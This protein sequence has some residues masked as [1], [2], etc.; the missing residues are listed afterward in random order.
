MPDSLTKFKEAPTKKVDDST[1]SDGG[2]SDDDEEEVEIVTVLSNLEIPQYADAINGD[3]VLLNVDNIGTLKAGDTIFSSATMF[4]STDKGAGRVIQVVADDQGTSGKVLAR[5]ILATIGETRVFNE[6]DFIDNCAL[7]YANCAVGASTATK[8]G[9]ASFYFDPSGAPAFSRT[10]TVNSTNPVPLRFRV[11]PDLPLGVSLNEET[12]L[13]QAPVVPFT[14]ANTFDL[15][16]YTFFAEVESGS[17]GTALSEE[18]VTST[19]DSISSKVGTQPTAISNY[20]FS[21][22]LLDTDRILITLANTTGIYDGDVLYSCL[23]STFTSCNTN[24][25]YTGIGTVYHVDTDNNQVYLTVADVN[26]PANKS[27]FLDGYY[28]HKS[29]GSLFT[30]QSGT[31][32]RLYNSSTTGISFTPEWEVDPAGD[33]ITVLF[34]INSLIP[35]MSIDT[36]SGVLSLTAPIQLSTANEYQITAIDS[37]NGES[38]A[39]HVFRLGVFDPPGGIAYNSASLNLG[40]GRDSIDYSPALTP[41][42]FADAASIYYNV[43]GTIVAG[44]SFDEDT[45]TFTGV[46]T[47]FDAGTMLTISAFHPRSGST[48]F[49]STNLTIKAGTPLDN[50]Y[51][52]QYANEYLQLTITDT[53]VFSLTQTI[54]TANGAQGVV[55]YINHDTN[56]IVVQVSTNLTGVQSFKV[57]DSLD[58][59]P[60]FSFPRAD[61]SDVV[62]IFNSGTGVT[63]RVPALYN[64][65]QAVTLAGGEVV[66]YSISPALPSDFT[67]FDTATGEIDG[68][69]SLPLSLTAAKSF[70]VLLTNSIG[71]ITSKVYKFLVKSA[72]VEATIGRYQFIR[73]SQ[74]FDRFFIGTRFQTQ[75][76]IKGRVVHKI[77]DSTTGG[78]LVEAQGTIE[79]GDQ[80]DNVNPYYAAEGRVEKYL[81]ITLKDVTTLAATNT[82]TTPNGDTAIIANVIGAENKLYALVT[83]GD[84]ETGE[85]I[86]SGTATES[87]VMDVVKKHYVSH[88]LKLDNAAPFEVGGYISSNGGAGSADIIFK[89]NTNH[90]AY[91]QVLGGE[92]RQG[93][94]IDNLVTY[95]TDDADVD[96]VVGPI[97]KVTSSG[98]AGGANVTSSTNA[99]AEGSTITADDGFSHQSAGVVLDV[100]GNDFTVDVKDVKGTNSFQTGDNIDDATPFNSTL[101]AANSITAVATSNI[102]P[103]Y[104]GEVAYIEGKIKGVFSDVALTPDSLPDGLSFDNTTGIIS[105]IPTEPQQKT[106]YTITY[107]SP[108]DA[109]ASFSFDLITYNQ[110]ELIQETEQASSYILH[111]E[112]EGYGTAS[113]KILSSQVSPTNTSKY[114]MND[115]VCRL[116]G[117]ELDLYSRGA[118]LKVKSGAGMCEYVRYIPEA[119]KS[120]PA[121]RTDSYYI[122]YDD[123]PNSCNNGLSGLS[124][125]DPITGVAGRVLIQAAANNA[126]R[127]PVAGLASGVT[128]GRK[129]CL[130]GDCLKEYGISNNDTPTCQFDHSEF[131]DGVNCDEGSNWVATVSCEEDDDTEVCDCT[132]TDFVETK[133]GGNRYS[134][135]SGAIRSTSLDVENENSIIVNS[136][137]GVVAPF[138]VNSP[139]SQGQ[140]R[141]T[142]ISN[143][144]RATQCRETSQNFAF[145]SYDNAGNLSTFISNLA[146]YNQMDTTAR[147]LWADVNPTGSGAMNSKKF[148]E[149]HCLDASYNVK[150]RI[151]LQVRDWNESFN[152][153]SP[154][155]EIFDNGGAIAKIDTSGPNCFGEECDVRWDWDSLLDS[156]SVTSQPNYTVGALSCSR[157]ANATPAGTITTVAGSDVF[158]VSAA[159]GTNITIGSIVKVG[160][161]IAGGE[162]RYYT[163]TGVGTT[164]F[165]VTAPADVTEVGLDWEVIRDFPFPLDHIN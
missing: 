154:E 142:T 13:L 70:T 8:V 133:C 43:A 97:I 153:E 27:Q 115:I 80:I 148:Y 42:N 15:A 78:L 163:V 2:S 36:N 62:H 20:N 86:N 88:V 87:I 151:R 159:I 146:N 152:P 161:N 72:P 123:F 139:Q 58:T 21:Y 93:D 141:N 40:I 73:L 1:S 103:I 110:F 29:N 57:G 75:A 51:Y 14:I 28:I 129:V 38:I 56:Q 116:E 99:F 77:G 25:E 132:V 53:S 140:G 26:G 54:S 52:P 111:K 55:S 74:N 41:A 63:S 59:A 134:C 81:F 150:A 121:G 112:G 64:N 164:T 12:G 66:T 119:H 24:T 39:T 136:F 68:D 34:N 113:C 30:V 94:D 138:T 162:F 126:T 155:V 130:T 145:D 90:Y 131:E 48:S 49:A 144:T 31:A 46:P 16:E 95:A 82:I 160:N 120:Y 106:T 4:K 84:F 60:T 19:V 3:L 89:E 165:T 10:L 156:L 71:E 128:F 79:A 109:D 45:G 147:G 158:T 127:Q 125:F 37:S 35:G 61:I 23:S 67:T 108:G 100:S 92:F 47:A 143:T 157:G 5:I 7:G 114:Q 50:F 98:N 117:G 83:S 91:I 44:I 107:S 22:K 124:T 137:A 33:G 85:I 135:M 118:E 32:S 18:E 104:V 9:G 76:G 102:I 105:G 65:S 96:H 122:Q 69:A 11:E 101:G 6:D 17:F 149:Y